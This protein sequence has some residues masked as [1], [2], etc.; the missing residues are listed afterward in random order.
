MLNK[1]LMS[2]TPRVSLFNVE[3]LKLV[4]KKTK[5][6]YK[7]FDLGDCQQ[8]KSHPALHNDAETQTVNG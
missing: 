2:L 4:Q 5:P 8:G 1:V 3:D 6:F 7:I